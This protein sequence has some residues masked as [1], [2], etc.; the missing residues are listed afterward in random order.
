VI[1]PPAAP[2]P[3]TAIAGTRE[4]TLTWHSPSS[5]GG[6]PLRGY[7]IKVYACVAGTAPSQQTLVGT[8]SVSPDRS[9][10]LIRPLVAGAAYRFTVAARTA[11]GTGK[12][13]S[14][15]KATPSA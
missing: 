11:T 8:L 2:S 10:R 5:N 4:V 1:V 15:V 7:V 6:D 3:L 14:K 12:R 9:S 13:T